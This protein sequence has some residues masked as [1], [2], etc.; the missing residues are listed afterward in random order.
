M[1]PQVQ[2]AIGVLLRRQ[3]TTLVS[4]QAN[5]IVG[6]YRRPRK[7]VLRGLSAVQNALGLEADPNAYAE[8]LPGIARRLTEGSLVETGTG[9]CAVAFLGEAHGPADAPRLGTV[10]LTDGG[11]GRVNW[12]REGSGT[13]AS[14]TLFEPGDT[15]VTDRWAIGLSMV[16]AAL[17]SE[18]GRWGGAA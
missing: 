14:W 9:W 1:D 16:L 3:T 8:A 15:E 17:T 12:G 13:E 10:V 6:V 4:E 11:I 5:A 2:Y 7:V 18:R